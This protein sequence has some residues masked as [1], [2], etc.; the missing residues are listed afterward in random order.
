MKSLI[1]L[2]NKKFLFEKKQLLAGLTPKKAHADELI[3][4]SSREYEKQVEK[5]K[6]IYKNPPP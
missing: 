4:I 2:K 3:D 5:P 1:P 6:K